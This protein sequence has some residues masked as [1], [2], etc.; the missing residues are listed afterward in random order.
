MLA[1]HRL[2]EVH[3]E[4]KKTGAEAGFFLR[5]KIGIGVPDIAPNKLYRDTN[6]IPKSKQ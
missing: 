4:Y 1:N 3:E 6:H 2:M 5:G